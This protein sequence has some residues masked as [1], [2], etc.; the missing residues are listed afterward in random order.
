MNRAFTPTFHE[1]E[2]VEEG[3]CR[4]H[5]QF[6]DGFGERKVQ[7]L[8]MRLGGTY[9]CR[10]VVME[11]AAAGAFVV[12]GPI[13]IKAYR[14]IHY[15]FRYSPH[16]WH[17]FRGGFQSQHTVQVR[18]FMGLFGSE[19]SEFQLFQLLINGRSM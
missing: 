14:A 1:E 7:A 15:D 13:A 9:V 6:M 2:A 19:A 8:K 10:A 5:E 12:L 16:R 11:I 4:R 3:H 17:E 18:G